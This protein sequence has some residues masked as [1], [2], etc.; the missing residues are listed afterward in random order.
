MD[1]HPFPVQRQMF[2]IF[3]SP[4]KPYT[5]FPSAF[6]QWVTPLYSLG[7]NGES[8]SSGRNPL[9]V[10]PFI[11][12]TGF[13]SPQLTAERRSLL[14]LYAL[15]TIT[16]HLWKLSTPIIIYWFISFST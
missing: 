10:P 12:G 4:L 13:P 1:I 6:S 7:R 15:N 3:S 9:M 2:F 14:C 5:L 8:K 11:T 16:S